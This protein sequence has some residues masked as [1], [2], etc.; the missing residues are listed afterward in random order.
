MKKVL[1]NND[2]TFTSDIDSTPKIVQLPHDAMQTEARVPGLPNGSSSGYWPG[3]KYTYVKNL[4]VKKEDLNKTTFLEFEGVYMKSTVMLNGTKVGGHIYGYTDFFVDL[5]GKLKEGA[6][7][8]KVIADNSQTPNTRWYSGSGIYRDVYLYTAGKEYIRPEGIKVNVLSIDPAKIK[9]NVDAVKAEESE[10]RVTVCKDGAVI[11]EGTGAEVSFEIKDARLWSAETPELYEIKAELITGGKVIDTECDTF[12]IRSLAWDAKKG[13]QVNGNT[14]KLRG[15]CVHHDHTIIGATEFDVACERKMR[16][17]KEAGFNA[18]R[19][20]H[21]PA[22]KA[23]LK[24]CDK[25]GMYVMNESFDTWLGLKSPYDYAMYFEEMWR[26]DLSRMIELSYNHPCVVIYS[27]GNEIYMKDYKKAAEITK[28]MTEF[29]HFLDNSRPV[30][31]AL[32]PL[33]NIMGNDKNP[34]QNREAVVDPRKEGKGSGL[35]GS[36]LANTLVSLMPKLMRIVGNEKAM[37]KRNG[38]LEPLDVVGFNYG[39]YLYEPQHE[40]YP[41]RILCGSETYPSQIASTWGKTEKMPWVIGDFLW[42]AWDYLGEAGIGTPGYGKQESI[43]QPFP[44]I[45]GGSANIDLTGEI[46]CQ[47]YYTA[48]VYG[49]YNKP[50]IAVHPVTHAGEKLYIGQWRFTDAVHSWSWTGLKGN[51]TKVDVYAKARMVEL[52][53]D[54]TSLG[55]KVVENCMATYDVEYRDGELK[56]VSYD[57]YGKIIGEDVL[58]SAGKDA[59]ITL[60]PEKDCLKAGGR[61]LLYLPVEITDANGVRHL[62]KDCMLDIKVEGA[63][64]LAAFGNAD[65]KQESLRP[66]T[67]TSMS[68]YEGR[69]LAVLRSTKDAGDIIVT[70]TAADMEPAT[71]TLRAK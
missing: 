32:N 31:N 30:I 10:I 47:G 21:H 8:I 9:V 16:I 61:D 63:A 58:V 64:E 50:Y 70:V 12:G 49:Q 37:R 67:G 7:E 22:S 11:A 5:T 33:C 13:L 28:E 42:T 35:A 23:M 1:W 39:D 19:I 44:A 26:D 68:S 18:V 53:Q 59:K 52:F 29:C 3:G 71:L 14:V 38:S 56:A 6:N 55:K 46:L 54:G 51:V 27:I 62:M 57:N 69:A 34:E 17:M 66:Y 41:E 48:I 40:D 25:L 4:D 24:A 45:I 43:T 60:K 20:A 36:Q 65:L 15:G 2:W